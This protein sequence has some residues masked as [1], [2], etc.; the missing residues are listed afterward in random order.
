ML[1]IHITTGQLTGQCPPMC[2]HKHLTDLLLGYTLLATGQSCRLPDQPYWPQRA[3]G[4]LVSRISAIER[5]KRTCRS[6]LYHWCDPSGNNVRVSR[7]MAPR[8]CCIWLGT[9]CQGRHVRPLPRPPPVQRT[10]GPLRN[11]G[12][13]GWLLCDLSEPNTWVS[14]TLFDAKRQKVQK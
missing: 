5:R 6:H 13:N 14:L 9:S 3:N 10:A 12:G 7:H 4:L 8:S 1:F 2:I 11:Q